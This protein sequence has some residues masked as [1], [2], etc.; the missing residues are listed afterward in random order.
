[1]NFFIFIIMS[2]TIS[3]LFLLSFGDEPTEGFT[4][5]TLREENFELQKP[6]NIPLE[7]RYSFENGTHRLWVYA[8]DKPHDPN[9]PTQPRTEIRIQGLDYSS[10]IWQFEGC[11]FVPNGTSGATI[12][13][14]HGASHGA[15]TIILRIYNGAMR[16]YSGQIFVTDLYDKWFKVN[17]IHNVDE[18]KVTVFIDGKQVFETKDQ[19]P[20][21]LHFKCG[22][23][24][25]PANISYYMESRWKDI[26]IYKKV[27]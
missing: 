9:S 23:Y 27:Y 14:I 6:Y 16:Y 18:G 2:S 25:A 20:G 13:Q 22:V 4:E 8:D 15:T 10:G 19:G 5:I 24:A 1:M 3:S 17:L 21:D 7:K 11:A 12:L 26:K